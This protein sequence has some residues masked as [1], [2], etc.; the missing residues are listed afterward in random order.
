MSRNVELKIIDKRI[1]TEFPKPARS[2]AGSAGYDL[3]A[4]VK[5]DTVI[6]PGETVFIPSGIAVNMKDSSMA[7]V[8]LPRSGLGAKH[9]LVLGNLVGLIDSD[10]QGELVIAAW[11]RGQKD[12][13]V[14]PGER[15]AQLVF[16]PVIQ[17]GFTEVDEFDKS[18]R[19]EGG[20]GSTGV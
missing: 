12:I 13:T 9:G 4:M 3:R 18:E 1:G 5:E 2:T 14:T 19:G 10:Y 11:N 16:L 8:V 7:A 20:F 15:I 17:A 6:H